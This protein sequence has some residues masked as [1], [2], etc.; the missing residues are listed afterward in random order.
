M[1]TPEEN[2]RNAAIQASDAGWYLMTGQM[3]VAVN[4][5]DS[6]EIWGFFHADNVWRRKGDGELSELRNLWQEAYDNAP[7]IPISQEEIDR[8]VAYATGKDSD[9]AIS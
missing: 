8:A 4:P 3:L 5:D 7:E 9:N 1:N 2:A 6:S